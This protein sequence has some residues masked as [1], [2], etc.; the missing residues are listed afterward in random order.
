[1]PGLPLQTVAVNV[2]TAAPYRVALLSPDSLL[3]EKSVT[4]KVMVY[5]R[6]NNPVTTPANVTI[7]TIG[8][9][10][11]NGLANA[12][13]TTDAN[14]SSPFTLTSGKIGGSHYIYATLD[15]VPQ[16]QQLPDTKTLTTLAPLWKSSNLNAMYML[17]AGSDR[18]NRWSY[19][20]EQSNEA[21]IV[22]SSSD[23][24]LAVTTLLTHPD[25]ILAAALRISQ[26]GQIYDG[27]DVSLNTKDGNLIYDL[28]N[29]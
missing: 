12:I 28:G 15:G 17:L 6:W 23:K 22:L 16:A 21:D 27:S 24:A 18:G 9:M 13:L 11:V 2:S 26:N 14:G 20:T 4:G 10:K 5:D 19:F 8:D 1:M 7:Q 25:R 3:P 29:R